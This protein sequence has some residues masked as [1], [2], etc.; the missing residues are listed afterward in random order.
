MDLSKLIARYYGEAATAALHIRSAQQSIVAAG[1]IGQQ[2]LAHPDFKKMP[3]VMQEKFR[4]SQIS[5]A[6]ILRTF[7]EFGQ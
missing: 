1:L 3:S 7:E 2:I 6:E 4:S 5:A